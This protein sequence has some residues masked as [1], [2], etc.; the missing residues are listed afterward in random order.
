MHRRQGD[1]CSRTRL[2][3]D[4][5][6]GESTFTRKENCTVR[7]RILEKQNRL[8]MSQVFPFRASMIRWALLFKDS[9]SEAASPNRCC[10]HAVLL[11]LHLAG[12]RRRLARNFPGETMLRVGDGDENTTLRKEEIMLETVPML[13][14][15][16]GNIGPFIPLGF[17]GLGA[18]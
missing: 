18:G 5:R 6:E 17:A 16:A 14:A 13:A 10:S 4:A 2:D 3:G 12:L 9:I 7:T 15:E 8:Q 1:V 11:P